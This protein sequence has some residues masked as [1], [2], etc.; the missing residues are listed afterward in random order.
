MPIDTAVYRRI[1]NGLASRRKYASFPGN[2]PLKKEHDRIQNTL[3]S[4]MIIFEKVQTPM[5]IPRI[6]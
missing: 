1:A 5:R 2:L 6:I 3:D 4:F